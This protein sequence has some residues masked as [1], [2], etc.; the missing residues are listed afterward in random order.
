MPSHPFKPGER[1][2]VHATL[3]T[4]GRTTPVAFGFQVAVPDTF[5][6]AGGSTPPAP[7]RPNISAFARGPTCARRRSPST[8]HAAA[9]GAGELLLAPYS[10]PGQYGPMILDEDGRLVWFKPLQPPARGP[11]MCVFRATA[12]NRS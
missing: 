4:G 1:V 5:G 7:S 6:E 8:A 12:A 10:G 9:H 11:P 2:A 3:T